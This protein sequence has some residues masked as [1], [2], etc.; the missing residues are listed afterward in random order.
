VVKHREQTLDDYESVFGH[1]FFTG[2]SRS[3]YGY[4]GLGSV[5]WHM[6]S[7]LL[8]ALAECFFEAERAGASSSELQAISDG[9]Y[10]VRQGMGFNMPA[11]A[12]GAFPSDP[13]SHTPAGRGAKQPGMTGQT[14]EDILSRWMELGIARS[15]G[16]LMFQPS[17]LRHE[18]F[19]KHPREWL[20]PDGK[21]GM[22][23]IELP[24]ES[25]AFTVCGVPVIYRL[26]GQ[27]TTTVTMADGRCQSIAGTR[28]DADLSDTIFDRTGDVSRI[29]VELC[30]KGT[31][32][33]NRGRQQEL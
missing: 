6:V 13:Y 30:P 14:K 19:L 11:H 10:R 29:T 4:E 9:Y 32:A 27:T 24:A 31:L 26:S 28:L 7:K 25:L 21:G 18:A 22:A 2:R 15:D 33:R 12:F 23:K 16:R 1:R 8:V 17:M 5:Y 3:M 20:V